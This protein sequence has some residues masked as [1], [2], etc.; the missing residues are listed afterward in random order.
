[1]LCI[2]LQGDCL[3][4]IFGLLASI[5]ILLLLFKCSSL[6]AARKLYSLAEGAD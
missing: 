5:N 3:D 2:L 1:M 6:S 4:I